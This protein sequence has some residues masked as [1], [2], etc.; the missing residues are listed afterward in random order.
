[1]PIHSRNDTL[2][3]KTLHLWWFLTLKEVKTPLQ[4]PIENSLTRKRTDG[5]N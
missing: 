5:W 2:Q 3:C 4:A 1:M